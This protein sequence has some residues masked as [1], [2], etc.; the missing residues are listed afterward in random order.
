M[1]A[2]P[3]KIWANPTQDTM[4][5]SRT[6]NPA[7]T[8]YVRSDVADAAIKEAVDATRQSLVSRAQKAEEEAAKYKLGSQFGRDLYVEMNAEVKRLREALEKYGR[9]IEVCGKHSYP[10]A[11]VCGFEQALKEPTDGK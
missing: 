9:H 1:E 11:C 4:T 10:H 8:E 3:E 6:T 7:Y 2:A 5:L